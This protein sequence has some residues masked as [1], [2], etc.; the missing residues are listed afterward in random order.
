M[1]DKAFQWSLTGL[2]VLMVAWIVLGLKIHLLPGLVVIIIAVVVELG[3]GGYF[4]RSWGRRYIEGTDISFS[5]TGEAAQESAADM[6]RIKSDGAEMSIGE[7]IIT[8]WQV[9]T[10]T[11]NCEKVGHEVTLNVYKDWKITCEYYNRWGP[12]RRKKK[13]GIGMA[14]S[15]IGIGSDEVYLASDCPGVAD[16]TSI[17]AYRDGLY[18]REQKDSI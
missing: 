8:D 7:K 15:W 2:T 16:C 3:L 4:L 17:K 11:I 1:N 18:E 6:Q 9:T 10:T 14:L 13:R 5:G 12:R